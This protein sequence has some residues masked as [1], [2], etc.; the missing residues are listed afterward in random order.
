[1]IFLFLMD[2]KFLLR[3]IYGV[4]SFLAHLLKRKSKMNLNK[5]IMALCLST[6][7]YQTFA[8]SPIEPIMVDIPSGSFE[9]GSLDEENA[10][11]IHKVVYRLLA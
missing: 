7:S 9:M 4:F 10:K 8:G 5:I 11:P 2:Y 6:M 1:M 3:F